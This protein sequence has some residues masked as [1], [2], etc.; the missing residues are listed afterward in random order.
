[1]DGILFLHAA[2]IFFLSSLL[3]GFILPHTVDVVFIV[4]VPGLLAEE[5]ENHG[6]VSDEQS[7]RGLTQVRTL[8]QWALCQKGST[9]LF[10]GLTCGIKRYETSSDESQ[11]RA[12]SFRKVVEHTVAGARRRVEKRRMTRENAAQ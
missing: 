5:V 6:V 2:F 3:S 12:S 10:R 4:D 1:M 7:L 9:L 11:P 8:F